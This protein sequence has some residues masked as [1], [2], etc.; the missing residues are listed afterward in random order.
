MG[1]NVMNEGDSLS[2]GWAVGILDG[3]Y[4]QFINAFGVDISNDVVIQNTPDLTASFSL[5]YN[6][7]LADGDLQIQNTISHR[8]DSSQFEIP[9]PELDQEA[10][11]LWNASAVWDSADGRWQFGVHGRNLTDEEYRVSGYD[12][13]NNDTLAPELGLEGTL[14]GYYG[15]PRTV[16]ATAA[17]RY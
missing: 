11:T 15:P 12:F 16:T 10:Y 3:E 7:P 9:F 4:D 2:L 8:G 5:T 6:T 1:Q 13:V 14:I 17:W